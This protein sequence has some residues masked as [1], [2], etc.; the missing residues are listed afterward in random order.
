MSTQ[1]NSLLSEEMQVKPLGRGETAQFRLL[2]AGVKEP[3]RESPSC[4]EVYMLS[5]MES[6]YDPFAERN[7]LIQNVTGLQVARD[8]G[9]KVKMEN[10]A[11]VMVAL[12]KKP[13]FIKGYINLTDEDNEQYAFLMRSKKNASNKFRP[14]NVKP[15]FELVSHKKDV[16]DAMQIEDMVFRAMELIRRS[17]WTIL[18]T[19]S[20]A[21]NKSSDVR[22]H[23]KTNDLQGMKLELIQKAKTFP[24]AVIVASQDKQANIAVTV[25]EGVNFGMLHFNDSAWFYSDL[26]KGAKTKE[27]HQIGPDED[28][29]E[30]LIKHFESEEG[31]PQYADLIAALRDIL[32]AKAKV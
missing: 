4:P 22:L 17:D 24:K 32:R 8:N 18:K 7:V 15:V 11:P 1:V 27:L 23:V 26:K 28:R 21:M 20:A 6:I 31:R 30:S 2:N 13:E 16:Q 25:F 3:G 14:G 10:N 12:T 5:N 19:I 9:G 29:T